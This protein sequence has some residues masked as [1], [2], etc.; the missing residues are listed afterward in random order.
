[1]RIAFIAVMLGL[2]LFLGQVAGQ[3]GRAGKGKAPDK[4]TPAR[5]SEE[6][7]TDTWGGKTL[8]QWRQ[9]MT[10]P[11]ASRRI[12]AIM[13]ILNFDDKLR[14]TVVPDL[15]KRLMDGDVGG[16]AKAC[17][18]LRYVGVGEKD[19]NS[20]V[21][22]LAFHVVPRPTLEYG[23]PESIIRYEVAVTLRRFAPSAGSPAVV[24]K[25]IEG[26][27]DTKSSEVRQACASILWRIARDNKVNGG[28]DPTIVTAFLDSI[29]NFEHSYHV[30]LEM[31]QGLGAIGKPANQ[32]L[33]GRLI[34]TLQSV[35]RAPNKSLALWGFV[36]LLAQDDSANAKLYLGKVAHFLDSPETEIKLQAAMALGGLGQTAKSKVPAIL[37]MLKRDKD[38]DAVVVH[39]ACVALAR[40]GDTSDKVVDA[41]LELLDHKDPARAASAVKAI[42]DLKLREP[43][44]MKALRDAQGNR[45][46][47]AGLKGWVDEA[48]KQLEAPPAAVK[49]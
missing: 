40:M 27:H 9:E 47:N 42:V 31:I 26:L 28:P 37:T 33:Q 32:A 18:V 22:A 45:N 8:Y 25:I 36:A 13:A 14:M 38:R 21:N 29:L 15:I 7:S 20:V 1:M 11:D 2:T 5:G 39:G 44:V 23:E 34:S 6:R 46:I 10:V 35:A 12:A 19:V 17:L 43:R 41:L 4:V 49:K 48:I 30:K 24:K 16:R 3:A